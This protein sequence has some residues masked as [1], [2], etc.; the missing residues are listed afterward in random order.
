MTDWTR[1][2]WTEAG[3]ITE[4]L[5]WGDAGASKSLSPQ[6]FFGQLKQAGRLREAVSFIALALPRFEAVAWAARFVRD[7]EP[8]AAAKSP[9]AEAIKATLLWIQDPVEARRRMA[10]A[11][12]RAAT[13]SS[14]EAM[15]AM[16]AYYSGGSIAPDGCEPLPASPTA[17][18][19]FAAGAVQIAA[20]RSTDRKRALSEALEAA[21]RLAST[22]SNAS[23]AA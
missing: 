20:A 16:A 11:S 1:V 5:G 15:V 19:R 3:Q 4:L 22:E 21:E 14:A 2:K 9:E 7:T 10:F 13:L 17:A 23:V 8:P 18:G 6:E 12:A